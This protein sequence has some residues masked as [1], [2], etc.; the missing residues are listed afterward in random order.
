MFK[1]KIHT[2]HWNTNERPFPISQTLRLRFRFWKAHG[3]ELSQLRR[4]SCSCW[5]GGC[6]NK[7][8]EMSGRWIWGRACSGHD[9]FIYSQSSKNS[10]F[11]FLFCLISTPRIEWKFLATPQQTSSWGSMGSRGTRSWASR[12]CSSRSGLA[13]REGER[14]QYE[15]I[16]INNGLGG[17]ETHRRARGR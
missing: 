2:K 9:D 14:E 12:G 6:R 16:N 11:L 17:S 5:L 3:Q 8:L 7:P 1:K 4:K 13:L 15:K 10:T